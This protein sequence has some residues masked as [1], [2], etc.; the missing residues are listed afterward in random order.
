MIELAR[1]GLGERD[2]L[3]DRFRRHALVHQH[4]LGDR[5]QQRDRLE[6]ALRM[7]AEIGIDHGVHRHGAVVRHQEGVAVGRRL[8][9]G[10]RA[11]D[12]RRT[13][14]ILDHDRFAPQLGELARDHA[15]GGVDRAARG[16]R[17]DD[18]HGALGE[19]LRARFA[20]QT[21]DRHRQSGHE[22]AARQPARQAP[23]GDHWLLP[24]HAVSPHCRAGTDRL[25]T[26][27]SAPVAQLDRALPSEGR[28][29]KFESC[30]AR[31]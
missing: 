15:R 8:R 4:D 26:C 12:H 17:H 2:Q 29:H 25:M 5:G 13:G 6:I 1:I 16:G 27:F 24:G 21:Q 10:F 19:A 18:A 28:G 22:R 30:R 7:V 20:R 3:P 14:A 11:D 9:G 31:Q 23:L